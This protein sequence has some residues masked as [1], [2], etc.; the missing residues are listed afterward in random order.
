MALGFALKEFR[1]NS[2][3]LANT[4]CF[5]HRFADSGFRNK[6]T[7]FW[8]DELKYLEFFAV[9]ADGQYLSPAS[10]TKFEYNGAKAVH[11]YSLSGNTVRETVFTPRSGS[12]MVV[13][14]V[15]EKPTVFEIELAVNIKKRDENLTGREYQLKN[16]KDRILVA[17][18]LG[19]L[20][21][22]VLEGSMA[23][24]RGA[25]RRT[26]RP[27]GDEQDYMTPGHITVSGK[28]VVFT[29]S[30]GG[31]LVSDY[32]RD[33]RDKE[34]YYT[35]LVAG[36]I[37]SDNED[38]V[39]GFSWS[40]IGIELLR[41]SAGK[42]TCF[43]A[44]LPWF[45][46]FW[47]RDIFWVLQSLLSLGYFEDVR[48]C[49]EFF[50]KKM[51]NGRLPNFLSFREKSS[52][53]S[54]DASLLWVIALEDYLL[55]TGD[56]PF[57]MKLKVPLIKVMHY[58]FD[59]DC[60]GDGFIEHDQESG[61]TWMDTLVRGDKAVEIQALY[62]KALCNIEDMLLAIFSMKAD[63]S[64]SKMLSSINDRI[65]LVRNSFDSL[66]YEDGFYADRVSKGRKVST[67]TANSLVPLLCGISEHH[68]DV[69]RTIESRDFTTDRGVRT[70]AEGEREYIPWGYHTGMA[71]SLTT[72]WA[73]A[74]EFACGRTEK[75]WD[76]LMKLIEGMRADALGCVGEC[77]DSSSGALTGCGLQ[78]WGSGFIPRLVD[79][80]MLGIRIKDNER[81]ITVS[82]QLPS[83]VKYIERE[84]FVGS[85]RVMLKFRKTGRGISVSCDTRSVKIIR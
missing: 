55:Q 75:G 41:K 60:D 9:K 59:R 65:F 4:T 79:E 26:H 71:W 45:Q 18:Q 10:C 48:N 1:N 49:L 64:I 40:V 24:V 39:E 56:M 76:Y 12:A 57:L 81:T 23:F 16:E 6:W 78:L 69:L 36:K 22:R 80:F 2:Y 38:L 30:A 44:G 32:A 46:Q 31:L 66:F 51:E 43:Y 3:F 62:F 61:E 21:F 29:V 11:H 74:A 73:S 52:W 82:P 14:L 17:N 33:L 37:K 47:G 54:I 20:E 13:E 8:S 15:S 84:V 42:S 34:D 63:K 70:R 85:R 7:G 67:R 58:L 35:G 53:N 19:K 5:F 28:K 25:M 50:A 77:W 27:G 72:A 68:A 83:A